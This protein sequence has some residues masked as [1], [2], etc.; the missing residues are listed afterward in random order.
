MGLSF[1]GEGF[2]YLI[3]QSR[4]TVF[5]GKISLEQKRGGRGKGP[6]VHYFARSYFKTSNLQT[7]RILGCVI[8]HIHGSSCAGLGSKGVLLTNAN[9]LGNHSPSKRTRYPTS[10]SGSEGDRE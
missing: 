8:D 7:K 2:F 3:R 5:L 9:R 4:G 6:F 1:S 10:G